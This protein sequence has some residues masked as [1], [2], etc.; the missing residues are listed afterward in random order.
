[1]KSNLKFF[2]TAKS[3]PVDKF[4]QNI[5]YDNKFGYYATQQPFGKKGD[6]ITSPKIS[7]LFSEMIA[8]W[9]ISSWELFGKPNNFNIVELGPGDGSLIRILLESFKKF[10]EFN[11]VKKIFL[12]EESSYLRKIQKKNILSKDVKWISNFNNI[13]KGPVIFFGNEFFDAIP[14]K[15]FKKVKNTFF[16]KNYSLDK[17]YKIKETFEKAYP[18]DIKKIRSYKSLQKLRFIEFPKFGLEELK[19]IVYKISK[20]KGCILLIDYGYLKPSNQST[21]QSVM[22]HKK[23]YFLNNLGKAD[24]TTHVNFTLLNEFFKKN[25]LK[26]KNVITQREFLENMGIFERAKIIA[27]KMKFSEQSDLYFRIKRLLSPGS[28][29]DLFKVILAFNFNHNN[30]T[31]FK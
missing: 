6:F 12:Y 30:F 1:M 3:L 14:L 24:I 18:D 8:I 17:N 21:I 2:K 19:K 20:L 16:E 13:K 23:N 25:G 10:P 4:F 5:L 29:G 28:M 11:S 15:Q 7:N 9:I 31:G 26:I 22:K 27:R